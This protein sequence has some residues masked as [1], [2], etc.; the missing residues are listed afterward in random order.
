MQYMPSVA[1]MVL[2]KIGPGRAK[3]L[4]SGGS[5]YDV[6]LFGQQRK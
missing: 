3:A 2:L 4:K 1:K 6:K 5:G